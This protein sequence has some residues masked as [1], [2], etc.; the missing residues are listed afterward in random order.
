MS[1]HTITIMLD[2]N[3]QVCQEPTQAINFWKNQKKILLKVSTFKH[4]LVAILASCKI[5]Q[6][7]SQIFRTMIF[8][9]HC[10][11]KIDSD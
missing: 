11:E 3:I 6:M 8:I 5:K 9:P 7:I 1:I 4:K 2:G 10:L